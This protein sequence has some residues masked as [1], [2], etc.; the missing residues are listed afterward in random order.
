MKDPE[1]RSPQEWAEELRSDVER[2][3]EPGWIARALTQTDADELADRLDDL[4]EALRLLTPGSL[5]VPM[6]EFEKRRDALL[7][8]YEAKEEGQ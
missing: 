5:D 2:C 3:E 6:S 1:L 8:K 4:S 7:A